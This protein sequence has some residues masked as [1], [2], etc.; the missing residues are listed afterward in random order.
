M[1][2][3]FFPF[4]LF[5]SLSLSAQTLSYKTD[6]DITVGAARF[7]A[8]SQLLRNKKVAVTGNHTTMVGE[9]HVVDLLLSKGVSVVRVFA[10]EHGFRGKADAGE[11]VSDGKDTKTGLDIVSLYGSHK[12][13]TTEDLNGI[14][15]MIFDIQDVGARFYTYISTMTYVMEACAENNVKVIVLDRPNPN[16]FYVDGPMLTPEYKSFVGMLPIPVV[17]GMT[18]GELAGMINEEGW[19]EGGVKCDLEVVTCEGYNHSDVYRLPIKPSPNLPNMNA[20][21]LYPSLCFFEGTT[22]SV[23]RG[24]ETPFE[25]FGHPQM[26]V[27]SYMFVPKSGP[28]SK[29][30]KHENQPCLGW[31]LT[32]VGAKRIREK[33]GLIIEWLVNAYRDFPNKEEFF[34]EN[35]FIHKLA[36]TSELQRQI[37]AGMT[38]TEI[39]K[40]WQPGLNAFK[41]KRSEY[42]LYE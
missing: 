39:R 12:K 36:G 18:V 15:V 35:G 5:L 32:E 7:E 29:Y 22:F 6:A 26:S 13:P 41:Q 24:T 28:G 21:L 1:R 10:P 23:G 37:E 11:Q 31:D 14:D 9:T 42:L 19:L 38:A 40:T 16:G 34:L 3:W 30:P 2:Y 27:G 25:V 8:Y 17:H 4:F 20:I 33:E